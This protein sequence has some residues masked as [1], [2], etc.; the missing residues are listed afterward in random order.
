MKKKVRATIICA[1]GDRLLLVSKD[2]IRWA[3]PGGRPGRSETFADAAVRELQEETTLQA[4]G[5]SFL[6]QVVGATTVHHVFVANIG[7][8]ASAKPC[9]EINRCQ[10]FSTGELEEV[11]VSATTRRIV[12]DFW[13]ARETLAS[14][15]RDHDWVD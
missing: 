7:K 15:F 8:S 11:I 2:G 14:A 4:K 5:L 3:L 6:F 13:K 9:K 10:W 12:D 1:R